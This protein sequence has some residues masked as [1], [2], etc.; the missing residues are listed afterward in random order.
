MKTLLIMFALGGIL[1]HAGESRKIEYTSAGD[2]SEPSAMFYA[3]VSKGEAPL[4]VG[5][6]SWSGSYTQKYHRAIDAWCAENGW[7]YIHPNFRGPN[8]RPEATGSKLVVQDILGAVVYAKSNAFI[9]SSAVFLVGTSG[10]GYTALVMVGKHLEVWAGVSAW[11]PIS[12]LSAWRAQGRYVKD[13]ESS[14]SRAPGD[15]ADVDEQY[16]D[17]SP[18]TD[19]ENAKSTMLNINAG[20]HDGHRGSVPISRSL[21]AFNTLAEPKDRLSDEEI[22]FLVEQAKVPPELQTEISDPSYGAKRPLFR[23]I[24]GNATVT[25]F[26]GGHELVAPAAIAW[27]CNLYDRDAEYSSGEIQIASQV[28]EGESDGAAAKDRSVDGGPSWPGVRH[29][30]EK[31]VDGDKTTYWAG[32]PNADQW[33]VI[34]S[35]GKETY[36]EKV[37]LVYISEA[38]V[39]RKAVVFVSS[40]KVNWNMI[41][42]L[43]GSKTAELIIGNTVKFIKIELA[44]TARSQQVAVREITITKES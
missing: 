26:D 18:I 3:P 43:P 33:E 39:A 7:A 34:F 28:T 32:D 22:R 35:L 15:S 2:G 19:L 1:I 17:R 31:L 25:I 41:A 30:R 10:G 20:I 27:F 4:V 42:T 16:A 38:F 9:D 23:R 12:D 40:D 36:V 44:G 37:S 13:L 11:V 5:L 29:L 14:C 6:H 24:S 21:L 8:N